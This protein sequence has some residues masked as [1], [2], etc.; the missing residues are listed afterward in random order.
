M[1]TYTES[2]KTRMLIFGYLNLPI[3][4]FSMLLPV[5]PLVAVYGLEPP[6]LPM[7]AAT[8]V[9]ELLAIAI[10]LFASGVWRKEYLL[11]V[12]G[13]KKSD[14]SLKKAGVGVLFGVAFFTVL[15]ALSYGLMAF[16]VDLE[17][18]DTSSLLSTLR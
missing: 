3:I 5:I 4:I 2:Q 7:L 9:G 16:G 11:D 8:V 10:C 6:V 15:Q 1:T 12:L 13:L 18:S 14:M 17:S